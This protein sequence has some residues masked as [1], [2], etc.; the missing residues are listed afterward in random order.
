MIL[1]PKGQ[2]LIKVEAQFIDGRSG[3]AIIKVLDKNTQNTMMLKLKF[4]QK[5]D[6]TN[7]WFRYNHI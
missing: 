7:I 6:I 4:V 2:R 1:K 3:L 5:S